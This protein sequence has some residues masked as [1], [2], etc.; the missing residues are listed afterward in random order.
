[1]ATLTGA[2]IVSLSYY[3]SFFLSRLHLYA[4]V[5]H[6]YQWFFFFS[7]ACC[8]WWNEAQHKA[9]CSTQL[10]AALPLTWVSVCVFV[11]CVCALIFYFFSVWDFSLL[12]FSRAFH[13]TP[14]SHVFHRFLMYIIRILLLF[15]FSV[16][17]AP[18][19]PCSWSLRPAV[20]VCM[21]SSSHKGE[22][23][24]GNMDRHTGSGT[25]SNVEREQQGLSLAQALA[26]YV[27]CRCRHSQCIGLSLR[28]SMLFK[29][30]F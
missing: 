30:R 28:L 12:P 19:P 3:C 22:C 17:V 5:W 21:E 23:R 15:S 9:K 18:V 2:Q 8:C 11:F 27:S 13:C 24:G 26:H 16:V 20:V 10:S 7:C 1:M 4:L 6:C 25:L 14:R 29:R